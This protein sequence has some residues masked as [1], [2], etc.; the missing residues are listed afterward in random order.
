M[1]TATVAKAIKEAEELR[2][3]QRSYNRD[4]SSTVYELTDIGKNL[5]P[6]KFKTTIED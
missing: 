5:Q 6:E 4:T 3:V 2:L 1:S